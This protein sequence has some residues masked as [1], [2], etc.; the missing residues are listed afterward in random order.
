MLRDTL[1]YLLTLYIHYI[2]YIY[3]V[4]FLCFDDIVFLSIGL[5]LPKTSGF[6]KNKFT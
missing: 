3:V 2:Y 6:V 5:P 4:Y 1:D